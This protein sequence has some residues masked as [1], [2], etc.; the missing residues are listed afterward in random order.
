MLSKIQYNPP[1]VGYGR[2]F[3]CLKIRNL[4]LFSIIIEHC[5]FVQNFTQVVV[6]MLSKIQ[7]IPSPEGYGHFSN[8][9]GHFSNVYSQKRDHVERKNN[10]KYLLCFYF[11]FKV[12]DGL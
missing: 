9:Y 3:K 6:K 2:F 7:S 5:H 4:S 1:P 10:K 11:V 8:V 12:F